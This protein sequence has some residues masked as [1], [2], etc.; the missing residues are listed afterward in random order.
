MYYSHLTYILEAYNA[1]V[2]ATGAIWDHNTGFLR[3]DADQYTN[4]KSLFFNIEDRTY[5]FN[6]NAQIW[7]RK[8]THH[9]GGKVGHVYLIVTDLGPDAPKGTGFVAGTTFLERF[10]TVFDSRRHRVC[11]A[12]TKF[13]DSMDIN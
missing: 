6:A 13:T 12:N 10:H 4:I 7:P 5:E 3:I 2:N 8:L 9:I 1:Y 11:L